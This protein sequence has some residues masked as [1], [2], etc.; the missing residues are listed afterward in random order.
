MHHN[1]QIN[2]RFAKIGVK[3]Q[4]EK[5]A[6]QRKIRIKRLKDLSFTILVCVLT[7]VILGYSWRMKHEQDL[8]ARANQ[9]MAKAERLI[10]TNRKA[11]V[12]RAIIN[13]V[14]SREEGR[15]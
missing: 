12:P 7:G 6:A 13:S 1:K 5:R 9:T 4:A 15:N 10:E 14:E 8:I 3:Q 11:F 2:V